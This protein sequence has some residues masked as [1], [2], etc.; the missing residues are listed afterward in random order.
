MWRTVA[1]DG[2]A[3][4]SRGGRP[5]AARADLPR[6]RRRHRRDAHRLAHGRGLRPEVRRRLLPARARVQAARV[7]SAPAQAR[8]ARARTSAAS[9]PTTSAA[10]TR[11]RPRAF[12]SSTSSKP[13]RSRSRRAPASRTTPRASIGSSP[14]LAYLITH[15]AEGGP[16]LESI[17][18]DWRQR[19]EEH[20]IY[21]D[22]SMAE[23]VRAPRHPHQRHAPAARATQRE[24]ELIR[25]PRFSSS[26]S[27][28]AGCSASRGGGESGGH[29]AVE[30]RGGDRRRPA[31]RRRS[32][33]CARTARSPTSAAPSGSGSQ[34]AVA[35]SAKPALGWPAVSSAQRAAEHAARRLEIVE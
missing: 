12:R 5:R 33:R 20:R 18:R 10:S 21:S 31:P 8:G 23:G 34:L 1:R 32:A 15:C 30:D 29:G 19:D 17:T 4:D 11:P 26:P 6:A 14:G 9:S 16:E 24:T 28:S 27:A 3:R 35:A 25:T 7:H 13:T 22:G 2:R